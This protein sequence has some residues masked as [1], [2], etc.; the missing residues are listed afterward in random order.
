MNSASQKCRSNHNTQI[1]REKHQERDIEYIVRL[2]N[3]EEAKMYGA[4]SK[5]A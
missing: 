4:N 5:E 1:L 3:L 2:K